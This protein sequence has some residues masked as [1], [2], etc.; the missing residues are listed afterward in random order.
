MALQ[1]RIV[2]PSELTGDVVSIARSQAAV[3]E[4]TVM[5]GAAMLPAGDVIVLQ[6]VREGV[7]ELL[8]KLHTLNIAEVG[9][10]SV[11]APELVISDRLDKAEGQ[12]AGDGADAI[13]WDEVEQDT[14]DDSKLTWSYLAFL[15]IAVQLAG[16]GIVTDSTIAIV[17]AMVV[18]PEFG[19]LAGLA[20]AIV[21]RRWKLARRAAAALCLGFPVA[22]LLAALATAASVW[23][24]LFSPADVL[25]ANRATEFI[26]HPGPYSFIVAVLAG[27][28][29]MLSLI[30]KKSAA[31][32][33]VF[34]SVTT[35]PAAGYVA[36]AL[37]LGEPGRAAGS[38]LQLLLNAAG[39]VLS[40]ALVL[41]GYRLARRR[42][43]APTRYSAAHARAAI[44][45]VG[46]RSAFRR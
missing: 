36:V 28:A 27:A 14:S 19:P 43:P 24:G 26:Y 17:G 46:S 12:V 30:G 11:T 31:L 10:L 33:G 38:A 41:L 8:Q 16:I 1:L 29:G 3:S 15:A 18:G 35:V 32:V 34:I 37:V 2:V 42:R 45:G 9:S 44:G 20:L 40:A 25:G 5:A 39:I 13:I 4:I 23:L 7:E 21:D 6:A 22:M